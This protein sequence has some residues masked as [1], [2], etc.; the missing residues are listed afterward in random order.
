MSLALATVGTVSV[1][2]IPGD[3]LTTRIH[4][5][6]RGYPHRSLHSRVTVDLDGSRVRLG[7]FVRSY[8]EKQLALRAVM[9]VSGVER[10]DDR[11]GVVSRTMELSASAS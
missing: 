10:I 9:S 11:I 8:Y 1:R 4:T 5:A 2:R 6:L 7:G 3:D